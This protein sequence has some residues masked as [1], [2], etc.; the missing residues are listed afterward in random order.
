MPPWLT[1]Q[2]SLLHIPAKYTPRAT[3]L[4]QDRVTSPWILHQPPNWLLIPL[5]VYQ[6]LSSLHQA[7]PLRHQLD[8]TTPLE[9][10]PLLFLSLFINPK[11]LTSTY[12]TACS[13]PLLCLVSSTPSFSTVAQICSQLRDFCCSFY[14]ELAS[15]KCLHSP[16]PNFFR[17]LLKCYFL[18]VCSLSNLIF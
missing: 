18:R 3:A 14:L 17:S 7:I 1:Q 13:L 5:L 10:S 15:S 6:N 12:K 8:P 16:F 2:Q 9:S 11:D 4:A